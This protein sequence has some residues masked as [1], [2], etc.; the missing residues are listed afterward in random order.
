MRF[1]AFYAVYIKHAL[2]RGEI[3]VETQYKYLLSIDNTTKDQDIK[4]TSKSNMTYIEFQNRT[5]T[6]PPIE[7]R[8]VEYFGLGIG[9]SKGKTSNQIWLLAEGLESVFHGKIFARY[10]LKDEITGESHPGDSGILYVNL[11]KLAEEK[12]PAGEL[13]G[14]LLGNIADPENEEVKEIVKS[15]NV[16]FNAFKADKE[17]VKMM[18]L[19]ER[20]RNEGWMDGVEEGEARGEARGEVK[21]AIATVNELTELI[22]LGFTLDEASQKIMSKYTAR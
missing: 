1:Y 8:A 7:T 21:G 12:N 17:A 9:Y 19:R 3:I 15:F 4:M 14:F 13:A 6:K 10:I 18:S 11:S 20:A 16:G 2:K 5:K 22:K